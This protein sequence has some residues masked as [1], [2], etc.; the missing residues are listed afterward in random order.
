MGIVFRQSI[1][2]SIVIF[3][4]VLLGGLFTYLTSIILSKSDLGGLRNLLGI[5]AVAQVLLLAGGAN[6]V[7]PY[8]LRY[9]TDD[10]RRPVLITITLIAP[11]IFVLIAS[12]PYIL[13]KEYIITR[14]QIVD[15]PFIKSYY[16]WLLPLS[17]LLSYMTLLEYYLSGQL[18]VAAAIFMREIVLRLLFL[19]LIS[20]YAYHYIE[21]NLFVIGSVL[22]H[23]I[24]ALLLLRLAW[25]T[26]G[27]GISFKWTAFSP[28]EYRDI[29]HY[30]WYHLL[31]TA[32]LNLI[33]Y[34]DALMLGPLSSS[35][36][37]DVAIYFNAQFL[38]NIMVA[39]Y[40]AM[41]SAAAPK[42]SEAYLSSPNNLNN[43][44]R[45]A[46]LNMLIATIAMWVVIAP[47]LHN[48]V[49]IL[50][51]YE[52]IAPVF[53]VLS[54]GKIVDISTGLNTEV[55][56]I[57]EYYKFNFKLSIFLLAVVVISD[58]FAIPRWGI[59]GAAW[60]AT[61]S[62]IIA[63]IAKAIFLYGK[64]GLHSY[65]KNT[66]TILVVGACCYWFSV[67]LPKLSLPIVDAIYRTIIIITV[68]CGFMFLFRPSPDLSDYIR[69][70]RK[71]KRL[72]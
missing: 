71:D 44:F 23:I 11:L 15:R 57:S 42:I 4:G 28:S 41:V 65:S 52:E 18:K 30:G 45:R 32:T 36:L 49:A 67:L 47:N 34:V 53:L 56:A 59:L 37:S 40:R 24:P 38:I 64:K 10:K 70:V 33:A 22:I 29:L 25:T 39:P 27:F 14:Y 55:I 60:V 21:L 17:L 35:G 1:K 58:R 46:G 31:T 3:I 6:L 66:F 8:L 61:A 13:F 54:I 68:Y 48:V 26:K 5:G 72:F 12:G 51:G 9:K 69:Q 50:P 19:M 7:N 2:G 16:I 20:L 43:L 62:T 63:N